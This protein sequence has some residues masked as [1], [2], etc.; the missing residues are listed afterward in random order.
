MLLLTQFL[1]L[2]LS[3]CCPIP[4]SFPQRGSYNAVIFMQNRTTFVNLYSFCRNLS[5][6]SFANCLKARTQNGSFDHVREQWNW[7]QKFGNCENENYA[8]ANASPQQG[9]TSKI[10]A[11]E[12][13]CPPRFAVTWRFSTFYS[14][15]TSRQLPAKT[16]PLDRHL[17]PGN[18]LPRSAVTWRFFNFLLHDHT[19]TKLESSGFSFS[20]HKL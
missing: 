1:H 11:L 10:H 18:C 8:N 17:D 20:P 16:H 13:M 6:G 9:I 15:V 14:M 5:V 4:C 3:R 19:K 2:L 7:K 12:R